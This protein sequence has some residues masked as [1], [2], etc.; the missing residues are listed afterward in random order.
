MAV[1]YN[2]ILRATNDN[3][4]KY[5]LEIV[6]I[7]QF[8]L[9]I[10]AIE[11]GEIGSV[12]GISSQTFTLP[13]NDNNN[14]F[15]N[16]VFDL[17]STPAV[18]LNKSVPCQVLVD[19]EAVFTGKLYIQNVISD[20]YNDVIYNCVVSNETVDFRILTENQ[21]LSD[22]NWAPYSHSYSY[23]SI[24]QSW[25]DQLFSGSIFYPLINYGAN[26][27]NPNSPGFEFGGAKYQMDNPTT[28]LLVSQFKPAVKV[29]TI[30]DEIFNKINY[31]YTSSFFSSSLFN[32]LYFLNSTED[33]DGLSFVNAGSGSYVYNNTT[34]SIASGFT[35]LPVGQLRFS[36][37][38]FNAGNNFDLTTDA[39]TADYTG[40][41]VFNFNIP[42][43]ITSLFG[44]LTQSR[45][46]RQFVLYITNG[47]SLANADRLHTSKTPLTNSTSGVINTGN[48]SVNLTAG[49]IVYF[50]FA[51]Q[52]PPANG[53]EQFTTVV[54][55]GQNGV[56]LKVTTPQNPVGGTVNIA[57]VFGDIKTLDFMKGLI[58]KFNLVIEPVEN[59]K[60]VLR[61]E[62]YNDWVN[63]GTTV[64][65][66]DIVDRSV[67]Y[68]VSHPIQSLPKKFKF[69]D[70]EDA[71]VLNQYQ[72]ATYNN[73]YG[74][75]TY[76]T[77]SDLA[78]GEKEIGGFFAAT[79]V[80]GIP[81]K[82]TNGTTVLPW[83]VKQEAG[84][85]AEGFAFKPRLLF[86]QPIKS[87]PNNEMYGTAT[88]SFS[89]PSGSTYYY[90]DDPAASGVRALS[91]Y[92]TLL[93]TT[94]SPT[95]F[96]SSLDIH[97]ANLGFYPYQQSAVNG[98]CQDGVYNRYW[99]YYI[100]S[101][102]D[103]DA[104]LLTC[105]IVLNPA[106]IKNIKLNDKI[107]IDGH[108]YRIN[109]IQGANL[110]QQQ[111]TT[112]ELIKII[113]RQ[114]PFTGRRRVPTG[115]GAQ[116]YEDVITNGFQEN[117]TVS[118]VKYQTGE[119]VS[120]TQVL[121]YVSA[122]DGFQAYGDQVNWNTQNP[123]NVNPNIFILGNSKY[124]ETQN[125]VIVVGAGN[126]LPDNLSESYIFGT[127]NNITTAV[128]A[129]GVDSGSVMG[130]TESP[131]QNITLIGNDFTVTDSQR[132]VLIQPS[133]S[134][135]V[136][137]SQN[138]VVINPISDIYESDPTGSV[139]TGNLRNQGTADFANG[140]TMTGSVDITGSFC[141][142]GVCFPFPTGSGGGTGSAILFNHAFGTDPTSEVFLT[143]QN[144]TGSNRAFALE[145]NL[146]SGSLGI[147][148]GQLQINTDGNSAAIVDVIVQ[149]NLT[150]APTA[151]FTATFNNTVPPTL[152]VKATFLGSNY[153]ISGSYIAL[154]D[155]YAGGTGTAGSGSVNTGSLLTT[156]SFNDAT[157]TFT[158]GDGST[159][160]GT[161]NNVSQS[162]V[163][164]FDV[165]GTIFHPPAA[166][167]NVTDSDSFTIKQIPISQSG[168]NIVNINITSSNTYVK[169]QP[170]VYI[171]NFS[172]SVYT[173]TQIQFR[174]T[175]NSTV[176]IATQAYYSSSVPYYY[177]SFSGI[178]TAITVS[179]YSRTT[180]VSGLGHIVTDYEGTVYV[181]VGNEESSYLYSTSSIGN[182]YLS[183]QVVGTSLLYWDAGWIPS[184]ITGSEWTST[185]GF[186]IL[187][188]SLNLNWITS[189]LP[190][191]VQLSGS[192]ASQDFG[193]GSSTINSDY[194]ALCFFNASGS[195]TIF[196]HGSTNNSASVT[197]YISASN[198]Y[199]DAITTTGTSS[200]IL[201]TSSYVDNT[202]ACVSYCWNN[203]YTVDFPWNIKAWYNGQPASSASFSP[204]GSTYPNYYS[205]RI[206][207]SKLDGTNRPASIK[208]GQFYSYYD[209]SLQTDLA[210][211]QQF[212][213]INNLYNYGL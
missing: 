87:I 154:K 182:Q 46:G 167:F 35:T 193:N 157:I 55:A 3:G 130:A 170:I 110:I 181:G 144:P 75:Y 131:Y 207:G 79:P 104:R 195:G 12:F 107:F 22:L 8:L 112:V 116:D 83:L 204:T 132:I 23:A 139:Y 19:G 173:D 191:Y 92:R 56:Y 197:C 148:S 137:G 183:S 187:S 129:S 192:G 213:F 168:L 194:S 86:K 72:K 70:S 146:T 34:Q 133:G 4:V 80:K 53:L 174:N 14:Q 26:P 109:K 36:N 71:D 156:A 126:T 212:E 30:V 37:A 209:S 84:K 119:P 96:T 159:F 177:S 118:Y 160:S 122:L 5:D 203:S 10:S 178:G 45:V 52:T 21:G 114:Q 134:R 123:T 1:Q 82:G 63:L 69:T 100:N 135:I 115:V 103:I 210:N 125:N 175:Q 31:K 128:S 101:L 147:N 39:Y 88:G 121:N 163:A 127:N 145:Y 205:K 76:Q 179:P 136:S 142:N 189:S 28:P 176:V 33:K 120:N 150:G 38:V 200:T 185:G 32:N 113:P 99:A 143:I 13:G 106:D 57:K 89:A 27:Q 11:L 166:T 188:S 158:K 15:F 90:I 68:Q 41:H 51:L 152:D 50:Y 59:T 24:S 208:V 67:K 108:L 155:L 98:T 44:P 199:V 58:E 202:W 2:V 73:I 186:Y 85:Y 62:P 162:N 164:N 105:N 151:S 117:G 17:G 190:Y 77:D 141:V 66:T 9:D 198:I 20:Q 61:I 64:D 94:D 42:F 153:I 124:N 91:Y 138:N 43:N 7:P 74:E 184:V 6:D 54:T 180:D 102:Y 78:N 95:I 169:L 111:S 18:A 25:N 165:A 93:P 172:G 40:T 60:N 48:I 29:K 49:Q 201:V 97:Y 211:Y 161:V 65:W 16:N 196:S 171:N 140:A 47:P 81:T 206:V 149:R